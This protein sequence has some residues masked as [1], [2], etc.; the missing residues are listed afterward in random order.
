[1]SKLAITR[2][3]SL[4]LIC[5]VLSYTS[6]E[7]QKAIQAQENTSWPSFAFPWAI[8]TTEVKGLWRFNSSAHS[9]DG[10]NHPERTWSGIDFGVPLYSDDREVRAVADGVVRFIVPDCE[11]LIRHNEEWETRSLHI[12]DIR[13]QE[14]DQV[15]KGQIIGIVDLTPCQNATAPHLHIDIK[16]NFEYYPINGMPIGGWVVHSDGIHYNGYLERD[17][18]RIFANVEDL[19]GKEQAQIYNDG[20]IGGSYDPQPP[21]QYENT[22]TVCANG[23]CQ[24]VAEETVI[25]AEKLKELDKFFPWLGLSLHVFRNSSEGNRLVQSDNFACIDFNTEELYKYTFPN[26]S[27]N[28]LQNA[29]EAKIMLGECEPTTRAIREDGTTT[30]EFGKGLVWSN[31]NNIP[32]LAVFDEHGNCFIP[33]VGLPFAPST[34][35]FNPTK[36]KFRTSDQQLSLYDR[37]GNC[38]LVGDGTQTEYSVIGNFYRMIFGN[39]D[40]DWQASDQPVIYHDLSFKYVEPPLIKWQLS[41]KDY[42]RLLKPRIKLYRVP[43]SGPKILLRDL[44]LPPSV[45]QWKPDVYSIG[46]YEFTVEV[47]N[48]SWQ[49]TQGSIASKIYEI[50]S[51]PEWYLGWDQVEQEQAGPIAKLKHFTVAIGQVMDVWAK[52]LKVNG[53]HPQLKESQF[54]ANQ[55]N[56]IYRFGTGE[57][58]VEWSDGVVSVGRD[59]NNGYHLWQAQT[60]NATIGGSWQIVDLRDPSELPTATPTQTLTPT[61]TATSTPTSLP[62]NTASPSLTPSPI[63]SSTSIATIVPT[64]TSTSTLTPIPEA[65][66]T[67]TSLPLPTLQQTVT[68][69]STLMATATP[70]ITLLPT[71]TATVTSIPG[72]EKIYLPIIV[73]D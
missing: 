47:A 53:N 57:Y 25:L 31:C 29:T 20:S 21:K 46:K 71:A 30:G 43:S 2:V 35:P 58:D 24:V 73:T 70:T 4:M 38:I 55:A 6:K 13:V 69:T 39:C 18:F 9:Y 44:T 51:G 64:W 23:T 67:A 50:I 15:F 41:D 8:N 7:E 66:V 49:S 52:A 45:Y 11:I 19:E 56:I 34:L 32:F 12:S 42:N 1:M 28:L 62:T 16:R 3:I 54:F 63:P 65:T 22:A 33:G 36:V 5:V 17:G 60:N 68:P 48:G 59:L 40:F 72:Q 61:P 37:E 14:R 10:P 26:T 27:L